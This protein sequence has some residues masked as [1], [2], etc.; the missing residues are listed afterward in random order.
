[1]F[2][3]SP[4]ARYIS[5]L[6]GLVMLG[7]TALV[8]Y[9]TVER[10][11]D[12][13]EWVYHTHLVQGKL[14]DLRADVFEIG[15]LA[16]TSRASDASGEARFQQKSGEAVHLLDET[17]TLVADN[18]SQIARIARLRPLLQQQTSESLKCMHQGDCGAATTAQPSSSGASAL[19]Q[20]RDQI[21]GQIQTM[22]DEESAL[23][24]GRLSVWRLLLQR[25]LWIFAAALFVA[26][27]LLI[28]NFRLI[29]VEL[30]ERR[31][32]EAR[33][34]ENAESYRAL[35][36][37][38]LELQ[39]VERRKLARELHDSVGQFL[40]GVK[41]NLSQLQRRDQE[42]GAQNCPL[43]LEAIEL[44]DRAMVEIR[45]I[46]HL[47]HP[48]LLDELGFYSAT[49]WYTEGF[50]KRS[51]IHVDL[52]LEAIAERLPRETELALFRVL[53]EALTNVYRH[54][55]ASSVQVRVSGTNDRVA[56]TIADNGKGMPREVLIRYRA[57][58]AGGIGLA[59]MR[60]RLAEL[61][62]TFE[63]DCDATGTTVRAELPANHS[64]ADGSEGKSI[65]VPHP[66]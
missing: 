27:L 48:P 6:I 28:Y 55:N 56:M 22:E 62:G 35:S 51:G 53:Q 42:A 49:R 65:Y 54:A 59:G 31:R 36:A 3:S 9:L 47:L 29:L 7:V 44:A 25:L 14:K 5:L 11:S 58:L 34:R 38:I 32:S 17:E 50:A 10:M 1:M 46:S 37:R 45:T 12:S 24:E 19:E 30:E 23:L 66:L 57:G 2:L 15:S 16:A 52:Q 64:D 13:R 4:A 26:L 33:E 41:I 43:L 61:D 18:P 20:R 21:A 63:V 60:E 40:A 39:D 8:G